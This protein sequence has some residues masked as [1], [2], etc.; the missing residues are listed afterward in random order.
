M[1]PARS[2]YRRYED[3]D[4]S[5]TYLTEPP[6]FGSESAERQSGS[7]T[8]LSVGEVFHVDVAGVPPISLRGVAIS[9]DTDAN[10]SDIPG[11]CLINSIPVSRTI[12]YAG[13]T[14]FFSLRS[15]VCQIHAKAV[16]GSG[17]NPRG[18]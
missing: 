4:C 14:Q 12:I 1:N 7:R 16:G 15:A 8:L 3:L 11:S 13:Q 9:S 6:R 2:G 10:T 18:S 17:D 5:P